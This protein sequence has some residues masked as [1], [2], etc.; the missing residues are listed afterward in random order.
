MVTAQSILL[1]PLKV[2]LQAFEYRLWWWNPFQ[3]SSWYA[4]L[5][6]RDSGTGCFPVKFTKFLRIPFLQKTS[7]RLLLPR[8]GS[9]GVHSK[10]V[11]RLVRTC[12]NCILQKTKKIVVE[13]I[14]Y[15][16]KQLG[17]CTWTPQFCMIDRSGCSC[18]NSLLIEKG[19][20]NIKFFK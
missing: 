18:C 11:F 4:T 2:K 19:L 1:T 9:E 20:C 5:L 13:S 10:Q 8:N 6:K 15:L 12:Q 17:S 16:V 14:S 3:I 7:T